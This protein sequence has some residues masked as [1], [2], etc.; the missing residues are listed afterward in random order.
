MGDQHQSFQSHHWRQQ[1]SEKVEGTSGD[2]L[3]ADGAGKDKLEGNDGADRFYFSGDEPFSKK[4]ADQV[5]DFNTKEGDQII[6]ADQVFFNPIIT[7]SVLKD[8]SGNPD[9]A[10]ANTKKDLNNISKEDHDFVYYKPKGELYIDTNDSEKGF[11]D[12]KSDTDPL[13]ANLDK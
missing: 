9:I 11:T 3:I 6:V 7:N 12:N 2:D 5:V 10:V 1:K 13:I 8:L 4:K